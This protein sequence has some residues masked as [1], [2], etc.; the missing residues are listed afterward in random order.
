MYSVFANIVGGLIAGLL[1]VVIYEWLRKPRLYISLLKRKTLTKEGDTYIAIQQVRVTNR[2]SHPFLRKFFGQ[3]DAYSCHAWIVFPYMNTG[4]ETEGAVTFGQAQ[5]IPLYEAPSF[6]QP[7][8]VLLHS[9][10]AATD[11]ITLQT[12]GGAYIPV[13]KK[14]TNDH[15]CYICVLPEGKLPPGEYVVKIEV[16]SAGLP[17]VSKWYLLKNIGIATDSDSLAQSFGLEELKESQVKT[18]VST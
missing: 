13:I 6:G 14:M 9:R 2:K 12:G 4:G 10:K 3:R 16:V 5:W 15:Y 11:F 17:T 1:A 7:Q 8:G 18:R